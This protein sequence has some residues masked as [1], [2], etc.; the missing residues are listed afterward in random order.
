MSFQKLLHYF[1][2][3]WRILVFILVSANAQSQTNSLKNCIHWFDQQQTDSLV[4]MCLKT[5]YTLSGQKDSVNYHFRSFHSQTTEGIERN[6]KFVTNDSALTF[7]AWDNF[8]Y[9]EQRSMDAQ[10]QAL[11]F[12]KM[13]ARVDGNFITT[14]FD[15]GAFI[16]EEQ[17]Q[18][19]DI[20][21]TN[22]QVAHFRYLLYRKHGSFDHRNGVKEHYESDV[23]GKRFL[24]W[25]ETVQNGLLNGP[26]IGY[27]PSGK[28]RLEEN[29]V[30]G[31]LSGKQNEYTEAGLLSHSTTYSYHWLY[32]PEK[33][34]NQDGEVIRSVNWQRN[35]RT[36]QEIEKKNGKIV[37]LI[38]YKQGIPNGKAILPIYSYNQDSLNDFPAMLEETTF[39]NG[40]KNG[41]FVHYDSGTK[42]TVVS[43]TYLNNQRHGVLR[44]YAS[45]NLWFQ[46]HYTNGLKNGESLTYVATGSSKE[47]VLRK[48][49]WKNGKQ[50][51]TELLLVTE[52]MNVGDTAR[53]QNYQNGKLHGASIGFYYPEYGKGK[54]YTV[55]WRPY[56]RIA[57]YDE[58]GLTGKYL[59][60]YPDSLH[61]EGQYHQ[62]KMDGL[63]THIRKTNDRT[64]RMER[65][66]QN[67]VLNGLFERTINTF[68]SEKGQYLNG[69][70]EG[71]W[72]ISGDTLKQTELQTE[73]NYREG[74]L[75]GIRSYSIGGKCFQ[76][77]SFSD[78]Q[79][80]RTRF[81][82]NAVQTMYELNSVNFDQQKAS[83]IFQQQRYDTLISCKLE[84]E[85]NDVLNH[86]VFFKRWKEYFVPDALPVE[87]IRGPVTFETDSLLCYSK[88]MKLPGDIY[89]IKYKSSGITQEVI[90]QDRVQ[91]AYFSINDQPFSG[92]FYSTMDRCEYRVKNG[93]L[94]GWI[95]YLDVNGKP[96]K[97]SRFKAGVLK[98]TEIL[99]E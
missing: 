36:G 74:K 8:G 27:Y 68:Y 71:T 43:G 86:P 81:L 47:K 33:W 98:K 19:V 85:T 24:A 56:S 32:G 20:P 49:F 91:H 1:C 3:M 41:N 61:V 7:I 13:D 29:Y 34:F 59:L 22:D 99:N 53:I 90:M 95:T 6:C 5:G 21:G 57:H 38:T 80:I 17:Y 76:Q 64:D 37:R 67:G 2:R 50:D 30:N 39:L 42:E 73:M 75:N 35:V 26:R 77:D 15:N 16:V 10:L 12:K 55:R 9:T 18:A 69:Q 66:Y 52:G 31:R 51:S 87:L 62:N 44:I 83:F 4:T 70:K 97:R 11:R 96:V 23:N 84:L 40:Q 54:E 72:S 94:N 82:D 89:W 78:D 63:W 45:G 28:I 58:Y 46:D 88:G 25:K 65:N 79:L 14:A 60:D 93:L 48:E 92:I